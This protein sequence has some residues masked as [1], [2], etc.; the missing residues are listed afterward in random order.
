MP[1]CHAGT[2]EA[3]VEVSDSECFWATMFEQALWH[4]LCL[5]ATG[6]KH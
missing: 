4:A 1:A 6:G 2:A 3:A 5:L